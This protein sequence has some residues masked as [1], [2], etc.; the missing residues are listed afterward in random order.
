MAADSETRK[1]ARAIYRI[2]SKKYP[3]VR[4]ELD[5]SNPL[6]L[7]I[8]TV[9]SAQCTDKRVN[10]VT[11]ALFKR[12]KNVRAYA[13]ASLADIEDLIYTTGF[14]RAKARHI[15]GLAIKIIEDF[16]LNFYDSKEV[17]FDLLREHLHKQTITRLYDILGISEEE[18]EDITTID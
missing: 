1:H 2:L 18:L 12:Y 11:P 4:C 9:L 14:F 5:F 15:K 13:K 10:Q 17:I 16:E 7:T 6:E 8:A 3:D